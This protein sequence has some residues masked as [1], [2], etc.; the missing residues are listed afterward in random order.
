MFILQLLLF[1]LLVMLSAFFSSAE[2]S[3]LSLNR[4]KLSHQVKKK[5]R[6][7]GLIAKL[8]GKPDEFLSTILIGNNLVNVA[9]ASMTAYIFTSMLASD[10][11]AVLLSTL[12]TTTVIVFFAEIIPK[13]YAMR[14]A[15][16]L[17]LFYAYPLKLFNLLFR[18]LVRIVTMAA[19]LFLRRRDR[20]TQAELSLEE[21][22]HFFSHESR[23][24][25]ENPHSL[26]MLQKLLDI[27]NREVPAIMTPRTSMAAVE[28]SRAISELPGLINSRRVFRC[29]VYRDNLDNVVG[30][31][32]PYL[33][34]D[35][36]LNNE[37]KD[38]K[39]ETI[40]DPPLFISEYSSLHY[41]LT[42]FRNLGLE[43]A[44][45]L[46]EYGATSGMLSLPD[47]L[48][49]IAGEARQ[50]VDPLIRKQGRR[51]FL[52]KGQAQVEE[53]NR[54][55]EIQLPLRKEYSTISG[56]FIYHFGRFP[57]EHARLFINRHLLVVR[58]MARRKINEIM[59]IK[60]EDHNS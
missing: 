4:I 59:I 29:A 16:R 60:H 31:T 38:L 24:F 3:F 35:F 37:M 47:I 22:K 40:L 52:V 39:I 46:D 33:L 56:L 19:G 34:F 55:L 8:L 54:Q 13:A 21:I 57:R 12:F 44:I 42:E 10:S 23:F 48:R 50:P 36:L 15:D 49:E 43:T 25:K 26:A 41:T 6:R 17:A 11:L 9:A 7:A 2:T 1:L 27:V 51:V 45:V 20:P 14:H 32:N 53:I 58:K 28:I 18:P 30:I 5:N